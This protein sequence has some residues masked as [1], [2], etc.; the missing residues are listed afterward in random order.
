M[1]A[2]WFV[3][4]ALA[5]IVAEITTCIVYAVVESKKGGKSD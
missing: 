5:T 2:V 3:M 1:N 4:G